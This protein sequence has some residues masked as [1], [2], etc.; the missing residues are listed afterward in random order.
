MD[1]ITLLWW[2]TGIYFAV[3]VVVLAVATVSVAFYAWHIARTLRAVAGGLTA[4][5]DHTTPLAD[6]LVAANAGL[7]AIAGS[8]SSARDHLVATDTGLAAL[9]GGDEKQVA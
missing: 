9:T 3:L 4:V 7:G 8:L 6:K 5:R 1:Q 2:L